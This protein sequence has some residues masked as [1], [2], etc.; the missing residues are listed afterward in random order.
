[1]KME[2]KESLDILFD[3]LEKFF[4]SETVIG[5]PIP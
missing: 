5:N 1:M 3:K 4:R 2:L